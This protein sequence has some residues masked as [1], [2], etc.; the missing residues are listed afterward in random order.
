[1]CALFPLR[2]VLLDLPYGRLWSNNSPG[3]GKRAD[4]MRR[5]SAAER[6]RN[7]KKTGDSPTVKASPE[8]DVNVNERGGRK[9]A[10]RAHFGGT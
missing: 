5:V 10:I 4:S 9:D 3:R 7:W 6:N 1:M 8:E 2:T